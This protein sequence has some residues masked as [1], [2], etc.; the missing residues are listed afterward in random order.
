MTGAGGQVGRAA[1]R[2]LG[3][4]GVGLTRADLDVTDAAAVRA[5]V[6][7]HRPTTILHAAAWTD[8]DGAEA[9]HAEA[10][11]ANVDA[12]A[13]VAI[14]ARAV[15]ARLVT[16]STDFVFDGA[17]R[18]PYVES[19]APAPLSA[20]GE[21]KLAGERAALEA[22][23]DGTWVVRTAWVY[24]EG[25]ANFPALVR[26][27]AATRDE[28]RVVEDQVGSPTYAGHL[29][30][31]LLAL[32]DAVPPG[33]RH[34]AGSGA[35]TRRAWAEAVLRAIGSATRVMP[36]TSDE[37]PTPARRPAYSALASEHPDTPVLPPW[38][39]GVEACMKGFSA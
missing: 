31:L 16:L 18:A 28:I 35:A 14:A 3:D 30:P 17:K 36:A 29:A 15:D 7:R 9:H 33:L 10:W 11:A 23:P 2:L 12:V 8:V 4:D 34:I 22:H 37:F 1:L 26:R 24:D 13:N 38:H 20:Y 25:E 19:D 39:D 5:A 27:L 6:E 32:P 21:S